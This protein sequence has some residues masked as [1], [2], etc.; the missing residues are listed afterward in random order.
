[1][2]ANTTHIVL[3][4][5]ESV[6]KSTLA[7]FLGQY[8]NAPVVAEYGRQY[9]KVHGTDLDEDG[10]IAI[11]HGHISAT[12]LALQSHPAVLVSDTD[13]LMTAAWAQLMLGHRIKP[14]DDFTAVGDLYLVPAPDVPWVD[15]GL[16]IH[17]QPVMR[18]KLHDLAM[19]ELNRRAVPFVVLSGDFVQRQAK[20]IAAIDA[21]IGNSA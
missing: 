6:G 12:Q 8:Y 18:H 20:A 13:P 7:A 5:A 11:L 9:C 4:G 14:L 15:D 10:L 1:M 16:R 21:F 17:A 19:K 3:H 2:T